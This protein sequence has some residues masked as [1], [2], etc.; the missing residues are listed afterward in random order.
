MEKIYANTQIQN[1]I[2]KT[3][4]ETIN[5]LLNFS[6]SLNVTEIEG[7]IFETNLN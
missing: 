7:M 6:K 5:F 2:V 3:K 1:K 4:P